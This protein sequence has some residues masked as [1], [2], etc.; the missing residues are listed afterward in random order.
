ML[1]LKGKEKETLAGYWERNVKET[2]GGKGKGWRGK[3]EGM[4]LILSMRDDKTSGM[5]LK[6]W[7]VIL[8]DLLEDSD[9]H[10][11]DQAKEVSFTLP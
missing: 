3:V 11:R 4:K 1:P 10:V 2:M 9:S 8:V 5:P 7:L 6:P